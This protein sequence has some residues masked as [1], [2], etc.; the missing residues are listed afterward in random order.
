MYRKLSDSDPDHDFEVVSKHIISWTDKT[1]EKVR[2]STP[3]WEEEVQR[4]EK[5]IATSDSTALKRIPGPLKEP[6]G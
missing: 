3:T 5:R 6:D 2:S 1:L 4:V